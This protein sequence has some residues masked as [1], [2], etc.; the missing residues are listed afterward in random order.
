[1]ARAHPPLGAALV[2]VHQR[3]LAFL[4]SAERVEESEA[5]PKLQVTSY[6][7]KVTIDEFARNL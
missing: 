6:E 3:V 5:V 7:F 2:D 4:Q 1:M